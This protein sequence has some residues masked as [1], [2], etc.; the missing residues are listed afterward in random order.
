LPFFRQL[1]N[2]QASKPYS[3]A[4]ELEVHVLHVVDN[5]KTRI[6]RWKVQ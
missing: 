3:L 5:S 4:K 2:K 6:L 1:Y